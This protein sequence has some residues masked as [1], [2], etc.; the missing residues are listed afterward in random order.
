MPNPA[1]QRVLLRKGRRDQCGSTDASRCQARPSNWPRRTAV[2]F[3]MVVRVRLSRAR[4]DRNDGLRDDRNR[5]W[6]RY[7]EKPLLQYKRIGVYYW[8]SV[9]DTPQ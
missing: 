2:P 4:D 1:T 6:G 3:G 7:D 9:M 5:S 8:E